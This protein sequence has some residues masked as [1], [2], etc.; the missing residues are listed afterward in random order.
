MI[1][2]IS[3]RTVRRLTCVLVFLLSAAIAPSRQA[4]AQIYIPPPPV[5][6]PQVVDPIEVPKVFEPPQI[7]EEPKMVLPQIDEPKVVEPLTI[8][9]VE[10]IDASKVVEPPTTTTTHHRRHHH[11]AM[12]MVEPT[13]E[14]APSL[15]M[16]PPENLTPTAGLALSAG[17]GKDIC[18]VVTDHEAR[19]RLGCP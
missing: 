2:E 5:Y 11:I 12:P 17:S 10:P 19:S 9:P 15:A 6:V 16:R 1:G 18:G 7:E 8:A 3:K 14:S 4:F 13:N